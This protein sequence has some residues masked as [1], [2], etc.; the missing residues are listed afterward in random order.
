MSSNVKRYYY[1]NNKGQLMV[2]HSV[3]TLKVLR[4][5]L[6]RTY[7]GRQDAPEAPR[8]TLLRVIT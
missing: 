2:L 7:A 5:R 6:S 3:L 1:K 4:S 8:G